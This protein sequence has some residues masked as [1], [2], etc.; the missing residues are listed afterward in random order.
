MDD[1]DLDDRLKSRYVPKATG[2][3]ADRIIRMSR[4]RTASAR[5]FL[6]TEIRNMFLLP[7]PAYAF[8]VSA[9][10]GL[11]LGLGFS[12]EYVGLENEFLSFLNI[13]EGD[14]L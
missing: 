9:V 14:W 13:E 11:L 5:V 12:G 4:Q 1:Y 3:L 7:D 10:L 2:D 8:A 6:W